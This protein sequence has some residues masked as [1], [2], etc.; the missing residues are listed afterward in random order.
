[1]SLPANS[2]GA[3]LKT[4]TRQLVVVGDNASFEA[5]ILLAHA[6]GVTRTHLRTWPRRVVDAA[7]TARFEDFIQRRATGVP[8]AYLTGTREFWSLALH[9][10]PDVLIPRA[11]TEVLV[12][13]ALAH[14]PP[15]LALRV[16][17]LGTGSGAVA[18]AIASER[19]QCRVVATDISSAALAVANANA[20]RLNIT[21]I[22]FRLGAWYAPLG[23]ELFDL[24]VSNPPYIA[25]HD[26]H[27]QQGDLRF[28]P[29]DALT[30]GAD[31]LGALKILI[32]E[33]SAHLQSGAWLL[34][35]HGYDQA[36]AVANLFQVHGA[37]DIFTA[38]DLLAHPRVGGG[39][40]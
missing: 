15:N 36:A 23:D 25:Q 12:E 3:L 22:E 27:L 18:L 34:V 9:V 4:A 17:D 1:M 14:L 10:T 8:I 28:E 29:R 11:E 38:Q 40:Y 30:A 39:R 37:H 16:A 32:G 21:N 20:R 31:E 2:I 5:E 13:C 33:A 6:L 26:S 24:I 7:I 35:E 19:P